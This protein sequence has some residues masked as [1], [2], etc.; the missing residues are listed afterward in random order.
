MSMNLGLKALNK[1]NGKIEAIDLVQTP[2][3]KTYEFLDKGQPDQILE[4]YLAWVKPKQY[5]TDHLDPR[6]PYEATQIQR[7]NSCFETLS[8]DLRSL[9]QKSFFMI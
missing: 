7:T 9:E 1:E 4:A 2:S 8:E 5:K 3:E 6:N